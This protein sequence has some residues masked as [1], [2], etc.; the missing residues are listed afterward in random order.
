MGWRGEKK[1]PGGGEKV[2]ASPSPAGHAQVA[3]WQSCCHGSLPHLKP[4]LAGTDRCVKP[5]GQLESRGLTLPRLFLLLP[6]SD[7][8]GHGKDG[9]EEGKKGRDGERKNKRDRLPPRPPRGVINVT[10]QVE[11]SV[12][13]LRQQALGRAAG[14]AG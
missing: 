3:K 14:I 6:R 13:F 12:N 10:L 4:F 8:D 1:H 9:W 5:R 2:A 7:S 11:S